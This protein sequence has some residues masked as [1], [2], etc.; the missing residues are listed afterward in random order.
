[1]VA[2]ISEVTTW[3]DADGGELP[4][5]GSGPYS[6]LWG[7]QGFW[8]PSVS[9]VEQQIP[10]QA[11]RLKYVQRGNK[12]VRLPIKIVAT[13][14][15][16]LVAA[17][18]ALLWA[19][20]PDRGDGKL[21]NAANGRTRELVCRLIDWP[22]PESTDQR[23]PGFILAGLTFQSEDGFWQDQDPTIQNFALTGGVVRILDTPIIPWKI[24]ASGIADSFTIENTG[25]VETWP[26][27]TIHGP[28]SAITFV[29]ETTGKA[30]FLNITLGDSDT[31]TIDT[32]PTAKS[33]L[34]QDGTSQFQAITDATRASLWPLVTGPNNISLSMIGATTGSLLT[35]SYKQRYRSA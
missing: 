4:L 6:V 22:S 12:A 14:E 32:D 10:K 31:L 18:D 30:L 5:D 28:G 20:D 13:S 24:A 9:I 33:I 19:T 16:D 15:V 27:W 2:T 11:P 23:L 34:L 25:H 8:G 17:R 26:L 35:L 21:R 1:M 7:R 3:V 29:N